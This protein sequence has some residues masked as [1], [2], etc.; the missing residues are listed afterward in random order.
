MQADLIA[1]KNIRMDKD[2]ICKAISH[3]QL[4]DEAYHERN[5]EILTQEDDKYKSPWKGDA[6]GLNAVTNSNDSVEINFKK[7]TARK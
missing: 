2:K 6:S 1:E 3:V 7:P 5:I 4:E